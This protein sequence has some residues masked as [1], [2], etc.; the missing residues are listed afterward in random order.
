MQRIE[1]EVVRRESS[2]SAGALRREGRLPGVFYGAGAGNLSVHVEAHAFRKLGLGSAGA[3]LIR[4][5]SSDSALQGGVALIK[6]VQTHPVNGSPIHVDFL[7]VDLNK[8]VEAAIALTFTGKAEGVVEGGILQPLRR[9]IQVRALPDKLP[10]TIEVDVT[11]LV[12]HAS[13]HVEE[14]T[15]P[16]GVEA[17]FAEN[18]AVV[19]VV[20]PV[21]EAAPETEGEEEGELAP[22]AE[23]PSGGD[24]AP[25]E[26]S[27]G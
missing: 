22:A 9:E 12:I 19:T 13:L 20:P 26:N 21:V 7:R 5:N 23:A 1:I 2:Q 6:A 8:P 10:E 15:M 4:F 24:D 3:H 11:P 18:Y 27:E 14:L 17:L 25:A 16:E